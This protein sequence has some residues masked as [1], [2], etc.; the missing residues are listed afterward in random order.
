[1]ILFLLNL[2]LFFTYYLFIP[3]V[4]LAEFIYFIMVNKKKNKKLL[5]KRL[6]VFIAIT[7]ILP[8]ILG[9]E[10]NVLQGMIHQKT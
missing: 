8:C 5:T 4:Y 2:G 6:I 10:F 9:F 3:F 1:M 7:L